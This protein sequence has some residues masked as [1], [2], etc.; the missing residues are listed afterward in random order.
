MNAYPRLWPAIWLATRSGQF[1]WAG[2]K[3]GEL[4]M[5]AEGKFAVLI[6]VDQL[7]ESQNP[8][9]PGLALITLVARTNR[10]ESLRPLVPAIL[11]ALGTLKAGDVV[12]IGA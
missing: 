12:R 1:G 5:H 11:E 7:L 3:N 4:L 8:V 10:I 2:L 9:P 6:T